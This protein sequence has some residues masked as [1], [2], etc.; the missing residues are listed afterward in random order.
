MTQYSLLII[1]LEN[2]A[3]TLHKE[4]NTISPKN[5]QK[6]LLFSAEDAKVTEPSESLVKVEPKLEELVKIED[7]KASEEKK[8]DSSQDL[9][10]Q[11]E[12]ETAPES[13]IIEEVP[14]ITVKKESIFD[15]DEAEEEKKEHKH[16]SSTKEACIKDADLPSSNYDPLE[17]HLTLEEK[18]K[19][20]PSHKVRHSVVHRPRSFRDKDSDNSVSKGLT[21]G[22]SDYDFLGNSMDSPFLGRNMRNN[23]MFH[24]TADLES[25]GY[26]GAEIPYGTEAS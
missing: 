4:N 6:K 13:T 23:S 11:N 3:E 17:A 5:E 19:T 16:H 24:T 21:A 18:K 14:K 9:E 2:K 1:H 15:D 12:N 20:P 8:V 7:N 26:P 10:S 22:S 25:S